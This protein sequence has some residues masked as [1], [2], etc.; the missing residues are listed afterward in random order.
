MFAFGGKADMAFC[1]ISLSRSLLGVKRYVLQRKCLL[2]TQSGHSAVHPLS[3]RASTA[4]V[5]ESQRLWTAHV[6]GLDAVKIETS[7]F[8]QH[9]DRA[10]EMATATYALQDRS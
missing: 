2:L 7:T 6:A 1:G 9:L 5:H 8:D 4:L 10:V 3:A